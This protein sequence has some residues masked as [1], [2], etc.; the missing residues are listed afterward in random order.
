MV[1]ERS[2]LDRVRVVEDR[3]K[4]GTTV[5][6]NLEGSSEESL[7]PL[8]AALGYSIAQ[9]LF[10][11]KKNVLIQGPADLVLLLHMSAMLE[12]LGSIGLAEG[13]F[14]PVGGLGRKL[15]I[16]HCL[17]GASKLK[18]VVL[19]DPGSAP[20]QNLESLIQQKLI[21]RK[22]VLDYS[23]FRTPANQETDIED[24][25]PR[26]FTSMLFNA[27]YAKELKGTLLQRR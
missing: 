17:L 14:V 9:N 21:Q 7:F 24:L 12:G 26:R 16:F 4:E 10:I 2:I 13:V 18:L 1:R 6:G 19:H 20:A 3:P 8:Q 11:A 5:T 22:Q 23:L 15:V 25:F 27:A